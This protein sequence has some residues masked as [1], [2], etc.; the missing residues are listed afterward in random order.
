M[1]CN[2]LLD[3][4]WKKGNPT[5]IDIGGGAKIPMN[6]FSCGT[7]YFDGQYQVVKFPKGMQVYHGSGSL[8]NNN[9]EF[10]LGKSFYDPHKMGTSSNIN[11]HQLYRD[12]VDQPNQSIAFEISKFINV[13]SGWFGTPATAEIYSLQSRNKFPECGSKCVS[14]YE[15]KEDCIFIL[16]DNNFNIW[17]LSND[18][19]VPEENKEQL[20]FM[21][22]LYE[23]QADHSD[24]EFGHISIKRKKRLS[25]RFTDVPFTNWL[26]TYLPEEYAGY[27]SN[28]QKYKQRDH[29][30]LEFTFFNPVKW[31]KRNLDNPIDWQYTD[32]EK[33]PQIELLLDQMAL[34]KSI[35]VDFHAGDLLEHSIWSLLFCE[36]VI[37]KMIAKY[38][39]PSQETQKKIVASALIHDIG[40][41]AP[42]NDKVTK[43]THDC[44]YFSIPEHPE[45]GGSYIRGERDLPIL[46]RNMNQIASFDMEILL[47][48]LG[49][50]DSDRNNLAKLIDL[51]WEFG[52]YLQKWKGGDDMETVDAY[53]NHVG[54]YE[55]PMFFFALVVVSIADILASQ[56]Y[57]VNNLT[58]ELNHHSRFFPFISNVP[59][60][61]RGGN[62]ADATAEKRNA[63]AERVLD[64]VI[65]LNNENIDIEME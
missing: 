30:H 51:H 7:Y 52:N 19:N 54:E 55:R 15:L 31:L 60:K 63:F 57:G 65:E 27:A 16:L 6:Y 1:A 3:W 5:E 53:I 48:E 47:S 34:Y 23:L 17:R 33:P 26:R 43:R 22:S 42:Y 62:L 59:K 64:R 41:M 44:I 49:F 25:Y 38:G 58:A 14:V 37:L 18:P 24:D 20:R 56:P 35:N 32:R 36:Q 45:I 12:V 4:D 61:Y 21:F 50:D 28:T 8:V 39:N 2:K 40:K 29:F 9:V 13:S 11:K 46:D 10:P